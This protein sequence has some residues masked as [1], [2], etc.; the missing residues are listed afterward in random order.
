MYLIYL[1]LFFGISCQPTASDHDRLEGVG[2]LYTPYEPVSEYHENFKDEVLISEGLTKDGLRN[3]EWKFYKKALPLVKTPI[4]I[5]NYVAGQRQGKWIY[6]NPLNPKER[7]EGDFVNDFMEGKWQYFDQDGAMICE[8]QFSNGLREGFWNRAYHEGDLSGFGTFTNGTRDG[9][10]HEN[11]WHDR[12]TAGNYVMGKKEGF[13][14]IFYLN[15]Q[16]GAG[17]YSNGKKEGFWRD[18]TNVTTE[19]NYVNGLKEGLWKDIDDVT[20]SEITYQNGIKHG[21]YVLYY[22]LDSLNNAIK[23]EGEYKTVDIQHWR[24][25]DNRTVIPI[26]FIFDIVSEGIDI[27]REHFVFTNSPLAQ[28]SFEDKQRLMDQVRNDVAPTS[29]PKA[30]SVKVGTFRTYHKT[31]RVKSVG[32][33]FDGLSPEF[34]AIGRST[35]VGDWTYFDGIGRVTQRQT[36]NRG[37][38]AQPGSG[39]LHRW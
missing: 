3:G 24:E 38:A 9:Y 18:C 10:W 21:P 23:E 4:V 26:E 5:G 14:K 34:H 31:G 1:L 6:Q 13:W 29:S 19:G 25:P 16:I 2:A 37:Q 20:I 7:I 32:S 36:Y 27:N 8:G 39:T 11:L 28:F 12:F 15:E 33:Y 17:S 30:Y 22:K 35:P